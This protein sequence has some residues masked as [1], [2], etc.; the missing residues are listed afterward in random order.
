MNHTGLS[1]RWLADADGQFAG[2][3]DEESMPFESQVNN[4]R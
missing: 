4:V 2:M 1:F 3:L